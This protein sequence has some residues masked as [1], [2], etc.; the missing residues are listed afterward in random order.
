MFKIA[1]INT[2]TFLAVGRQRLGNSFRDARY[3]TDRCSSK[4]H[5][6]YEILNRVQL[7]S[8]RQYSSDVLIRSNRGWI[9]RDIQ[10]A[11]EL[12]Q[13]AKV[14]VKFSR[15]VSY[16]SEELL[17]ELLKDVPIAI[18][19]FS[20]M[21]CQPVSALICAMTRIPHLRIHEFVVR[22]YATGG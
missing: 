11:K 20:M 12:V 7:E 18:R 1:S 14:M 19:D 8:H 10:M 6:S 15:F 9:N 4:G 16:F 5:A 21:E 3:F 13:H 22:V 17:T 2:N